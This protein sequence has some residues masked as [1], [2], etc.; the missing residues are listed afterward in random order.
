MQGMITPYQI[1]DLLETQEKTEEAKSHIV[2]DLQMHPTELNTLL[3]GYETAVFIWNIRENTIRKSF[4]LLH[5]D[6]SNPY[7]NANLTSLAWSPNGSRFIAGY[8][9]GCTHLWDIK[10]DQKPISSRKLS[11]NFSSTHQEE[12]IAEPI[13]Q[14]AWYANI[15]THRSYIVV[16]GGTHP[17]D[18]KGLNILEYDLDSDSKEPKKQSIMPLPTDLSHFL[19]LSTDPYYLGMHNPFGIMVVGQDHCLRA[20][21]FDHGYPQFKLPPAL[22]FLGPNVSHAC[23][24]SQL[25]STSYKKLSS[26]VPL[27]R[28]TR[29]F[30]ITGGV[31]GPNHIYHVESNDLLLT[32]HQGEIVKFWDASYTALRPLSHLTIHCLDDVENPDA[33]ICCLDVNKENGAFTIGFSD[34]TILIYECF[35]EEPE[36][37][38]TDIKLK[39]RHEEIISSCDDTLK[40]I[41]GLLEDMGPDSDTEQHDDNTNPFIIP[42]PTQ[43]QSPVE[44][45]EI[46]TPIKSKIFKR[47]DKA[48][49]NSGFYASIKVSLNSPIKSVVSIGESM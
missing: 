28:K 37:P 23:H 31:A 47:L 20:Y 29:Y 39:S 48:G 1:P 46:P 24:L 25:P 18:I 27:D 17:T 35:I 10:N 2:V 6:K 21:S 8:D 42:V 13:Y 14:I 41:S 15:A 22:E 26:I 45:P 32:I 12:N 3:I 33:F 11:Q 9:D 43:Q 19:I 49:N 44:V 38:A 16:A 7:R 36:E 30:P 5:L 4:T 40:E 34:G